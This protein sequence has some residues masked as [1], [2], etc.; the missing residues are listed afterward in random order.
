MGLPPPIVLD[1]T[2]REI[3]AYARGVDVARRSEMATA[4]WAA[5]SMAGFNAY[6][7][8]GKRLPN[9]EPRLN[10][11]MNP[12]AGRASDVANAVVR[13]KEIAKVR[14]LPA[15]KPRRVS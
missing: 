3:D 11:I 12:K 9:I 5:W 1:L 8:S 2:I 14:N 7:W 10:S 13:M 15:P 6:V 4:L